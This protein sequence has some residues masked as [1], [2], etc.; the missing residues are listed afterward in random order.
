MR[1]LLPTLIVGLYWAGLAQAHGLLV[2][3]D[4]EVS[5]LAMLSH[6]VEITIEDQVA[7]TR[8]VQTFRNHTDRALEAT[9]IFPVPKG[10]SV[11]KFTMWVD[12]KEVRGE[13]VEAEKARTIYTDVVRRLQDPGLLEYMDHNLLRLRVFPVPPKGDQKLS[14][15][16]TSV[17]Q[18]DAGLIEYVYPLKTSEKAAT[19]LKKFSITAN[20]KSQHSIQNIYS[21]GH[22]IAVKR[23]SDHEARV[24]F[25]RDQATLDKDFQLFYAPGN[26]DVGLTALPYRPLK[27]EPG[28]FMLLVSPRAELGKTQR[29]ARDMVFVLDTSGSMSG[30]KM[31]QARKAL[32]YCLGNLSKKD[33][34]GMINFATTVN[35]YQAALVPAS[36]EQLSR[37]RHWVDE[38][39]A[40]GGTAIDEALTAALDMRSH[41]TSRSFTVVFF[42]DG[43]PTIGE[44][45]PD[46]ILKGVVGK[47]TLNT[48]I[49]TFGVGDDV[50]A[51]LLDK[52]ADQTR[53][54][55]TYVRPEEDIE[56]KVSSLYSKISHPVLTNLQLTTGKGVQLSEVYPAHLPDLFHDGQLVVLGRYR[57]KGHAT[58]ILTGKVGKEHREFVYEA[59]FPARTSDE[60][61]FV[62]DVWAR[63]KVGYLLDQIRTNGE[64]KELVDEV[65]AL[66]KKHGI[67]T[68]YTSYLVVPDG[69]ATSVADGSNRSPVPSGGLAPPTVTPYFGRISAAATTPP[70]F[71][72]TTPGVPQA[73][74]GQTAPAP[75]EEYARAIQDQVNFQME[76]APL[77]DSKPVDIQTGKA[78]VDFAVQLNIL[79]TQNQTGNIASRQ[80][81]GRNCL[82]I[83]GVW[84][85]DGFKAKMT[86]V[87]VKAQSKAY[88]RILEKYPQVK[89][90]FQ[91][92]NRVVWVTPANCALVIDA[93]HGK[94]NLSDAAIDRLFIVRK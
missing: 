29:V 39:E 86:T 24:T 54:L 67:T 20:L 79:R 59:N 3:I 11:K 48:R 70:A 82:Q 78:G 62:Q 83:G 68:P 88:F 64:K 81:A 18:R 56:V 19:T 75:V 44:T 61:S 13:L 52:L 2:P 72:A 74:A 8:V 5:P 77:S 40:T 43:Q 65:V 9:Y 93:N 25:E 34:F 27:S 1:R 23:F 91:L 16:Y 31:D 33:R 7:V 26:K 42:T 94:E 49:F 38:L 17:V 10:A 89:E 37:A 35:R 46:N 6:H 57:G 90:V 12:G 4:K 45:D 84:I 69:N 66:A 22:A 15:S 92:G 71:T 87:T 50:N 32:K 41:D 63:R 51:V 36:R 73:A 28:Y 53:A 60:K 85:D 55:S 14:L 80:A 47:N 76:K 30:P 21:P 58:V